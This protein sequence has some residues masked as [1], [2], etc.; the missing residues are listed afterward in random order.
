MLNHEETKNL[1]V[2]NILDNIQRKIM[3][4]AIQLELKNER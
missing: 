2:D 3:K 1:E 4:K